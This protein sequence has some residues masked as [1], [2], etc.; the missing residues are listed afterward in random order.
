MALPVIRPLQDIA[1]GILGNVGGKAGMAVATGVFMLAALGLLVSAG[2]VLLS[3]AVGYPVAALAFAG[4]FICL[5]LLTY[6]VDRAISA[7]RAQSVATAT[8]R[9]LLDVAM[10][11]LLAGSVRPLVPIAAFLAAFTLARRR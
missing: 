8:N 9:L 4:G 7:R 10:T 1:R 5:A 6:L 11:R 2:L 3:R